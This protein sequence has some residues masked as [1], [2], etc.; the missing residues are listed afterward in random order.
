MCC[1]YSLSTCPVRSRLTRDPPCSAR[2]GRHH[3][4]G[5]CCV[6]CEILDDDGCPAR[7][8]IVCMGTADTP[9]S[10]YTCHAA[11][12]HS[13]CSEANATCN[14]YSERHTQTHRRAPVYGSRCQHAGPGGVTGPL[15]GSHQLDTQP[16]PLTVRQDHSTLIPPYYQ[17]VTIVRVGT[18]RQA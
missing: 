18:S 16:E 7:S 12:W 5:E 13:T 14:A 6:P 17:K 4:S 1:H 8:G 9:P 10:Y 15:T 2:Y 11:V 3:E